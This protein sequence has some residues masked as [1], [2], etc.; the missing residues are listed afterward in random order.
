M[1]KNKCMTHL[2][3]KQQ[4]NSLFKSLFVFTRLCFE[5]SRSNERKN[6]NTFCIKTNTSNEQQGRTTYLRQQSVIRSH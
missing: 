5:L 6:T 1:F 2:L 3:T 4:G